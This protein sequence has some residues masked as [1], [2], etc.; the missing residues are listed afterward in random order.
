MSEYDAH[1]N[2]DDGVKAKSFPHSPSPT[3]I[4][5]R[6]LMEQGRLELRTLV[7][8]HISSSLSAKIIETLRSGSSKTI[9]GT[10]S[11]KF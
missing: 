6:I 11:V 2:T 10:A 9:S 7:T 3:P 1:L 4:V 8:C 5:I